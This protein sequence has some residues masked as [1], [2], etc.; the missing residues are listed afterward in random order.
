ME[1]AKQEVLIYL[2]QELVGIVPD[3]QIRIM[4]SKI[5]LITRQKQGEKL[6]GKNAYQM[7]IDLGGSTIYKGKITHYD[8]GTDMY[9]IDGDVENWE[10]RSSFFTNKTDLLKHGPTI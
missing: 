3:N 9:Y 8:A 7:G 5:D 10:T 4:S 2:R 6:I 1:K